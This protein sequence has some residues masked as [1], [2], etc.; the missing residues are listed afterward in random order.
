MP[1]IGVSAAGVASPQRPSFPACMPTSASTKHPV[2]A[3]SY[4]SVC[5]HARITQPFVFCAAA[6][7]PMLIETLLTT[8]HHVAR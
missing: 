1:E 7:N 5:S 6:S 3:A 4:L 8:A 2:P